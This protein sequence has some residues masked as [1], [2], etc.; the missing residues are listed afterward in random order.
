MGITDAVGFALI[1]F[2]LSWFA[3]YQVD[4][5]PHSIGFEREASG[6]FL[7]FCEN[8]DGGVASWARGH[9]T[10]LA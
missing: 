10:D 9:K 1:D 6:Y 4:F 8:G 2:Y 3:L 7:L 5:G